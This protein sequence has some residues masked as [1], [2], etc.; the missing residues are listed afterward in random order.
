MDRPNITGIAT[1]SVRL[2]QD[3]ADDSLTQAEGKSNRGIQRLLAERFPKPDVP[4]VLR[5]I[6]PAFQNVAARPVFD[7]STAAD[8]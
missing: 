5:P 8:L 4:T 6:E 1:L 2:A 3:N 7:I